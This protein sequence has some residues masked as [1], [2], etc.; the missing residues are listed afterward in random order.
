ME[1]EIIQ[2]PPG[3]RSDRIQDDDLRRH[4]GVSNDVFQLFKSIVEQYALEMLPCVPRIRQKADKWQ[5]FIDMV[6]AALPTQRKYADSWHISA[7]FGT[8]RRN[9]EIQRRWRSK[10]AD[11]AVGTLS[12]SARRRVQ[13]IGK[14]PPVRRVVP[15]TEKDYREIYQNAI[16]EDPIRPIHTRD[17]SIQQPEENYPAPC[18]ACGLRP[19][20]PPSQTEKLRKLFADAI[21]IFPVLN[22]I[23]IIHDRHLCMVQSW[24]QAERISFISSLRSDQVRPGDK[25]RLIKI[26][27]GGSSASSLG[28]IKRSRRERPYDPIPKPPPDAERRLTSPEAP[29]S[30]LMQAMTIQSEQEF[31][32]ILQTIDQLYD[33]FDDASVM[34]NEWWSQFFQ[35][36]YSKWPVMK[37]YQESGPQRNNWAIKFYLR[38]KLAGGAQLSLNDIGTPLRYDRENG[39]NAPISGRSPSPDIDSTGSV[40]SG[41]PGFT[42]ST[43]PMHYPPDPRLVNARLRHILEMHGSE[44]LIPAFITVEIKTDEALLNLGQMTI[45]DRMRKFVSGTHLQLTDLQKFALQLVLGK[46]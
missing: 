4:M 13:Y 40:H 12:L 29:L 32:K 9:T 18:T 25:Q 17:V 21:D 27:A 30:E 3:L 10:S 35:K 11:R 39:I 15:S 7:Y 5:A 22:L 31:Y 19:P 46:L 26:L 16:S 42:L 34:N 14:A 20:V 41:Y 2:R 38:R 36:I 44:D 24:S 43:C 33:E 8:L 23:G 37:L 6:N 28:L 45:Q 1:A